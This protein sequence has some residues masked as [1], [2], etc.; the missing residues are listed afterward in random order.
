M[1]RQNGNKRQ[2][3][4]KRLK[5]MLF[6]FFWTLAA[7]PIASFA[8]DTCFDSKKAHQCLSNDNPV[9][10][11][12]DT[13]EADPYN[14]SVRFALCDAHLRRGAPMM[15]LI[16][17][18]HGLQLCGRS[19]ANCARLQKSVDA[20]ERTSG[21]RPGS[22]ELRAE[23]AED[24]NTCVRRHIRGDPIY[25]TILAC[26]QA[27]IAFPKD[28]DL[29]AAHGEKLLLSKQPARAVLAFRRALNIRP[30][31]PNFLSWHDA[32][33]DSRKTMV[34][35]CLRHTELD[36]CNRAILPGT[37]DEARLHLHRTKLYLQQGD[38]D[39]AL[40]SL[41]IV[42]I[43]DPDNTAVS[44]Q[45][46]QLMPAGNQVSEDR[47]YLA[48]GQA[49]LARGNWEAAMADL[50]RVRG[51]QLERS[52]AQAAL[53]QARQQRA[54]QIQ[55]QCFDARDA[56]RCQALLVA[57]EPDEQKIRGF[58]ASL[59]RPAPKAITRPVN[60]PVAKPASEPT[61]A[62]VRRVTKP[63]LMARSTPTKSAKEKP[64]QIQLA[65]N[66]SNKASAQ[67]VTH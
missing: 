24:R 62:P 42:Q 17:L 1:N 7:L 30:G 6:A 8:A 55:S 5:P 12:S 34:E 49:Q 65:A 16:T 63:E 31:D 13:L 19:E 20:V 48:R 52:T 47:L 58:I 38:K 59:N 27:L 18:D 9:A 15:A 56:G 50:K 40:E 60:K 67:G 44:Q 21:A 35:H 14:L 46:L 4:A 43:L 32:A 11:C 23:H 25:P 57:G 53:Q 45:L 66:D 54:A 39:A 10:A 22:A 26:E 3:C 64:V 36:Q 61:T 2:S 51:S 37:Q 29:H 41:L 28:A 33:E